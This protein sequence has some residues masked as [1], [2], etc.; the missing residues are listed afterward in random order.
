MRGSQKERTEAKEQEGG[1]GKKIRFPVGGS[2]RA[3]GRRKPRRGLSHSTASAPSLHS[4]VFSS[5]SGY[6]G[7]PWS[8]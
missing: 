8:T 1:G 4:L 6:A 7:P 5:K 3:E 2:G